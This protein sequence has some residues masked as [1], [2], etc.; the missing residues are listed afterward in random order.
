M[1]RAVFLDRDGIINEDVDLLVDATDIRI[2]AGVP[3][4]LRGL[5][6]AGYRLIVISNQT[7]VARGLATEE[8]VR[9]INAQVQR[10]LEQ[11]GGP[12][13][14]GYYFCPHHPRATLPAYRI[15]CE[16]RKPRPGLLLQAAVEHVLDL[17]NSF[18]AGDR[19]TDIIAGAMTGCRT[20]LVRTGRDQAAPIETIEPLDSSIE[21]DYVCADLQ[22]AARWILSVR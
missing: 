13:L 5:K 15:T 4:A 18:M 16:C 17:S 10:V 7:V 22:Q 20:V 14:D 6:E 9:A 3:Q 21:P 12:H 8:D 2:L 19:V 1:N 11:A